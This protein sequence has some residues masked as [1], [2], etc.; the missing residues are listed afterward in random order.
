MFDRVI[1][2]SEDD[3]SSGPRLF[4]IH[5]YPAEQSLFFAFFVSS[6]RRQA[7][8]ESG[9]RV[10]RDERGLRGARAIN[11]TRGK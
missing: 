5:C 6:E 1:D 3:E 9:V 4:L 8:G 11:H 2:N 10:T 7:R